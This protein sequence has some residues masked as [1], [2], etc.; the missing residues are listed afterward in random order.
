M[1]ERFTARVAETASSLLSRHGSR[2][3]RVVRQVGGVWCIA[4]R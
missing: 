4:K 2:V 1:L 3:D